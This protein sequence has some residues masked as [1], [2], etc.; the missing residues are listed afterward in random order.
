MYIVCCEVFICRDWANKATRDSPK[1][2][3]CEG[4]H[5]PTTTASHT[6]THTQ[7]ES[8]HKMIAVLKTQKGGRKERGRLPTRWT[9]FTTCPGPRRRWQHASPWRPR[10]ILSHYLRVGPASKPCIHV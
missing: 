2:A 5:P 10:L 9:R 4:T 1:R 3:P 7:V 6:A 8:V